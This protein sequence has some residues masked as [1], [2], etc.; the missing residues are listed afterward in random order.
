[1]LNRGIKINDD[2]TVNLYHTT[3]KE[4][5]KKIKENGFKGTMA[6]IGGRVNEEIGERSFFGFDRDWVEN[7]WGTGENYETIEIKVPIDYIRQGAGNKNEVY[8]EG[9]IKPYKNNVWIPDRWPTSTFYDR[10]AMKGH[11]D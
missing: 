1:M 7:T 11:L 5:V 8:I 4:N 3:L 2:N 10:L 6:P 9:N